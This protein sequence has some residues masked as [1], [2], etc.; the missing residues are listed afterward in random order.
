MNAITFRPTDDSQL[1]FLEDFAKR[2]RVPYYIVPLQ[3]TPTKRATKKRVSSF[4]QIQ[5]SLAGCTLTDEEI[6]QECEL[7]RSQLY[8]QYAR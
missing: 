7:V 4:T 8:E 2:I 6:R 3:E 1:I 5:D